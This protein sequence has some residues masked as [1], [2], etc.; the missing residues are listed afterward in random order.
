MGEVAFC[1]ALKGEKDFNMWRWGER[2]SRQEK[3]MSRGREV[4]EGKAGHLVTR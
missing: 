3:N 2:D 1:W 4:G